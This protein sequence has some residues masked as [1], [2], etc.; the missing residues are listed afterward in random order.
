MSA[1]KQ[2]Q[3]RKELQHQ[4]VQVLYTSQHSVVLQLSDK[5]IVITPAIDDHSCDDVVAFLEF[6]EMKGTK[7]Q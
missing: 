6:E 5:R 7:C 4:Q 1:S 3:L 2:T